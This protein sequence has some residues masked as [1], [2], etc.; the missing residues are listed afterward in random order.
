MA[1][2]DKSKG[3]KGSGNKSRE[4]IFSVT[5]HDCEVQEFSVGGAGGQ[6]RDKKKT[7]IKIIHPPSGAVGQA[8]EQRSQRQNKKMAFRRMAESDEFKLWVKLRTSEDAKE[9]ARVESM[10]WGHM[11]DILVE[12]RVN[13]RWVKAEQR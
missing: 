8:T 10:M 13:G 7:G 3:P 2:Q 9:I 11:K 6:R 12:Y 1:T 5:I 4:L